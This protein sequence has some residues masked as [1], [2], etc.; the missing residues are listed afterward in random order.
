MLGAQRLVVM[1]DSMSKAICANV[2]PRKGDHEYA[3][4]RAVQDIRSLGY[5]RIILKSDQEPALLKLK[6]G[7][8]R[9]TDVE[10]VSEESPVGESQS[11]G[12]VEVTAG[13]VMGQARTM[14]RALEERYGQRLPKE[15]HAIP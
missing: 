14:L 13:I 6:E 5:K 15:H 1:K 3:V 9:A 7:I 12:D 11:N 2:V 8:V 4:M 10:I